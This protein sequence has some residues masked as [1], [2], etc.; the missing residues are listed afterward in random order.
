MLGSGTSLTN[1]K[2]QNQETKASEV[3]ATTSRDI[4]GFYAYA[5]ACGPYFLALGNFLPL[6]LSEFTTLAATDPD[7]TTC[8]PTNASS[9]IV[10][11][12]WGRVAPST[13]SM[14]MSSIAVGI[15]AVTLILFSALADRGL[16]RSRFILF[17]T[18][19]GGI[20]SSTYVFFSDPHHY[21]PLAFMTVLAN[22]SIGVASAFYYSYLPVL[23]RYHPKVLQAIEQNSHLP[24]EAADQAVAHVRDQ[25]SSRISGMAL[26]AGMVTGT[27]VIGSAALIGSY[28]PKGPFVQQLGA[29]M[30]GMWWLVLGLVGWWLLPR[31][32][33]PPVPR[34]RNVFTHSACMHWNSFKNIGKSWYIWLGLLSW[35]FISDGLTTALLVTIFVGRSKLIGV[36]QTESVFLSAA[37]PIFEAIALMMLIKSKSHFFPKSSSKLINV[38]LAGVCCLMTLW[39]V[40]GLHTSV[41]I[42]T[43]TEYYIFFTV[44]V[45]LY[46]CL[47]SFHRVLFAE[48]V[49]RGREA[50]FFGLYL[51]SSRGTSWIGSTVVAVINEQTKV[52]RNGYY[53]VLVL[54]AGGVLA[55]LPLNMTRGHRNADKLAAQA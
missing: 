49:P 42:Q 2:P 50:E 41:G 15:Q 20:S 43:K 22:S 38:I 9:C 8:D 36:T 48:L 54:F 24:S 55:I 33:G 1:M 25:V 34:N 13:L 29:G 51:I 10:G 31:V 21:L 45:T 28:M 11:L 5:A 19:V 52:V 18:L 40:L 17:C 6:M 27:L 26:S 12:L 14:Y 23:V 37:A 53:F 32:Q 47:I 7:G 39:G 44:F 35:F 16:W 30:A 4:L 46:T 3:R